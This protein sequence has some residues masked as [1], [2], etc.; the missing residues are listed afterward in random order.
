MKTIIVIFVALMSAESRANTCLED[1]QDSFNV[2]IMACDVKTGHIER[3]ACYEKREQ[4]LKDQKA[5]CESTAPSRPARMP[6]ND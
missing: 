3:E 1:A 5:H 6:E 2:A 4:E